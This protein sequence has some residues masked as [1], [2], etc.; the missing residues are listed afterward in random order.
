MRWTDSCE[1]RISDVWGIGRKTSARLNDGGI[2]TVRDLLSADVAT[3]RRQF[4][5][6][7]EKTLLELR[8]TP[9]LEVDDAP[10]PNQQIMCSRSFGDPVTELPAL[11]EAVSQ[12]A[13]RV[14][15]KLRGQDSLAASVQVFIS[16]SPFRRNDRQHSPHA[17]TPLIRP[18]ADTRVLIAAAVRALAAIYRPGYNYVKA[19]VM[20]VDLR[21]QG[22]RKG[23]STSSRKEQRTEW[24]LGRHTQTLMGA[25]NALN[26]RFGRGAVSVAS[27]MRGKTPGYHS[28]RERMSPRYTTRLDEVP[29][30][31]A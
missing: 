22:R 7:L 9:C 26:Q 30:A 24:K 6:V 28:K 1:P 27:A 5:V 18:S 2:H 20:L 21:P 23:S 17:T 3:L 10:S 29:V 13:S 25:V 4:S 12:F 19:G 11:S 16:T 8:G 14:A 31:R 15:E